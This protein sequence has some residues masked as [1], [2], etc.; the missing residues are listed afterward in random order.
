MKKYILLFCL[1]PFFIKNTS[2]QSRAELEAQRIKLNNEIQASSKKLSNIEKSKKE[3]KAELNSLKQ[4]IKAKEQSA[5]NLQKNLQG[6]EA[7]I[8]A[9]EEILKSLEIDLQQYKTAYQK[10]L[11][12]IY[13]YKRTLPQSVQLFLPK[14]WEDIYRIQGYLR[15]LESLRKEQ[16]AFILQTQE[17][18]NLRKR[19]L[20]QA[21]MEED[22]S[23]QKT[24]QEKESI[25]NRAQAQDQLMKKLSSQELELKKQI[26][27]AQKS[28]NQ[29]NNKIESVIK[30]EIAQAKNNARN[31]ETAVNNTPS[32]ST[33]SNTNIAPQR[34]ILSPQEEQKLTKAILSNK[35]KLHTPVWG[36][37]INEYGKR[38][39]P[40]LPLVTLENNGVD[41][42][43]ATNASVFAIYE[44]IIVNI[45]TIPGIGNAI[46]IKHGD[47]YSI[48]AGLSNIKVIN[49]QKVNTKQ[50]IAQVAKDNATNNYILH[51]EFWRNKQ[52]ENPRHWVKL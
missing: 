25:A 23:L 1:I 49:G 52:K 3:S 38:Q 15:T 43:T 40:D 17:S 10:T 36:K 24:I 12:L 34:V 26:D 32:A 14:Y 18:I 29:L 5:A 35:G 37:V 42:Q 31:Y 45:F 7:R 47:F 44:G 13:K 50:T 8:K 2:A 16:L 28:K 19:E 48:Y 46:M 33:A 4:T 11:V 39:H 30:N 6:L 27:K 51:F 20:E 9:Q 22:A 21:K 41:I